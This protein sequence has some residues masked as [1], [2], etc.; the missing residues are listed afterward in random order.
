LG[1][2]AKV[3]GRVGDCAEVG[4]VEGFEVEGGEAVEGGVPRLQIEFRRRRVQGRP[5][6]FLGLRHQLLA[7]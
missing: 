1:K 3:I 6:V 7:F 4:G 5:I 2:T